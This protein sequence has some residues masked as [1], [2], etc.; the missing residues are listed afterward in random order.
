MKKMIACVIACGLSWACVHQKKRSNAT[1]S[2]PQEPEDLTR[3]LVDQAPPDWQGENY[4]QGAVCAEP[5]EEPGLKPHLF[6]IAEL[7]RLTPLVL[8]KAGNTAAQVPLAWKIDPSYQEWMNF[9]ES[10][11]NQG[12]QRPALQP[13]RQ[14]K[15]F[16]IQDESENASARGNLI[17]NS[18]LLKVASERSAAMILCH[19]S[20]H[21]ARNHGVATDR[22]IETLMAR[23]DSLALRFGSLYQSYLSQQFKDKVYTHNKQTF[24][25]L[26]D[27]WLELTAELSA[28][29][30]R[31]ESEAD[32][33]GFKICTEFG[34]TLEELID[35]YYGFFE[36]KI[37]L[38]SEPQIEEKSYPLKDVEPGAFLAELLMAHVQTHPS[39]RERL[40]QQKR[41]FPAYT[42]AVTTDVADSW[43]SGYRAHISLNLLADSGQRSQNS[44]LL[45]YKSAMTRF[46]GVTGAMQSHGCSFASQAL[47]K[48][49]EKLPKN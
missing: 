40:A 43:R 34:F 49:F 30:R 22:A 31:N 36:P 3:P 9:A 37:D 13:G 35:G 47:T 41:L 2:P 44:D 45:A 32:I 42:D 19:E 38:P 8:P 15:V 48:F 16:V 21:E 33:A 10:F 23:E 5:P 46:L 26:K 24:S 20:A 29:S 18:G 17:F 28:I 6:S 25:A 7:C 14:F 1:P 27:A 12:M 39:P 4:Q 11:V